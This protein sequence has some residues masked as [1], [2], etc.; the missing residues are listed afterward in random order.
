MPG[1]ME[2]RDLGC[3]GAAGICRFLLIITK[4]ANLH[5][6]FIISSNVIHKGKLEYI[7]ILNLKK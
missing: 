7:L 3:R 4:G 5:Q 6:F 2:A 1:G